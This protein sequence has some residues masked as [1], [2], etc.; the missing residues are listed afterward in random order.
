MAEQI[1]GTV[2]K[3]LAA[4]NVASLLGNGDIHKFCPAAGIRECRGPEFSKKSEE[5]PSHA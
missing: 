2:H 3:T 1:V 4:M 5:R